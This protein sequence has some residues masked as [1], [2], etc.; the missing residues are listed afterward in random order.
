MEITSVVQQVA[1][2][3]PTTTELDVEELVSAADLDFAFTPGCASCGSC[4][5]L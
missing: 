4:D 5:E 1:W 3:A 2:E